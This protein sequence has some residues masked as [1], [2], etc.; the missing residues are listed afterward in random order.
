MN[1]QPGFRSKTSYNWRTHLI[2]SY[3]ISLHFNY[4]RTSPIKFLSI[5]SFFNPAAHECDGPRKGAEHTDSPMPPIPYHSTS[6]ETPIVR[7]ITLRADRGR[8]ICSTSHYLQHSI[9][10]SKIEVGCEALSFFF[11]FRN[12]IVHQEIYTKLTCPFNLP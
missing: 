12:S 8:N 1:R 4:P 6:G 5:P 11:N 10:T 9:L 3:S 2:R 7:V